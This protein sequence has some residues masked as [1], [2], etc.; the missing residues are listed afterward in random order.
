MIARILRRHRAARVQPWIVSRLQNANRRDV[1]GGLLRRR[2]EI[3]RPGWWPILVSQESA[4][5]QIYV[6]TL[7]DYITL[8]PTAPSLG[9][10]CQTSPFL[11]PVSGP[12]QV[13]TP[14]GIFR[15]ILHIAGLPRR[16]GIYF[17]HSFC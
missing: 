6:I 5:A 8:T 14:F 11:H 9:A 3:K 10:E 7:R 13:T 15:D 17:F 4:A 2:I 1:R 16:C 12:S